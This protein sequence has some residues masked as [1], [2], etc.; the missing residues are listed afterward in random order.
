MGDV[1]RE[2]APPE[3]DFD[4][5]ER[6]L[7]CCGWKIFCALKRAQQNGRAGLAD[8]TLLYRYTIIVACQEENRG[9][10]K[11]DGW[12]FRLEIEVLGWFAWCGR[13]MGGG[14]WWWGAWQKSW[15]LVVGGC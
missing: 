13:G 5:H 8:E 9:E 12:V 7:L 3:G 10:K 14:S 15:W 1:A 11:I 6:P 2:P 4:G